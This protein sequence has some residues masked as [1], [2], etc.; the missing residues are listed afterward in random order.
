M[1]FSVYPHQIHVELT[2]NPAGVPLLIIHGGPGSGSSPRQVAA[3][4]LSRY[5]VVQIDQRGCG[6]SQPSGLLED[7]TTQ[8]LIEDMETLRNKLQIEKWLVLGGS[9]GAS[10][11]I[12]YAHQNP[13]HIS[14]LIL[15]NTFLCTR[16]EVE[17][18]FRGLDQTTLF[19]ALDSGDWS[20]QKEAVQIW[21]QCEARKGEVIA[22]LEDPIFAS[23]LQRYRIQ[24]HYIAH[25]FFVAEGSVQRCFSELQ[26][27]QIDLLHGTSDNICPV[28]NSIALAAEHSSARLHLIEGCGHDPYHPQMLKKMTELLAS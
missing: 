7:N 8:H 24:A 3:I 4:D 16:Q 27:N 25:G 28:T 26:L 19:A 10:L 20:I 11:A 12:L 22:P 13:S 18:F 14:R 5:R 9:W 21:Q 2:G 6:Q 23:L 1:E 15:R 17:Q